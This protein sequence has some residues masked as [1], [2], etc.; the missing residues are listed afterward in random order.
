[1]RKNKFDDDDDARNLRSTPVWDETDDSPETGDRWSTWDQSTAGERGPQPY[2]DWLV[3]DLAAVDY[4]LGMVKTGKEADVELVRRAVPGTDRECLLAAKRYRSNQHR[5]FHRDAGYLEGRR[6]RESRTN[7]ATAKRTK[8]GREAIASQ[9]AAAEFGALCQLWE[10]GREFG[11]ELVP[12]PVQILGT[13]LLLEFIGTPEGVAAPRLAELRPEPDE[14]ADLWR[15][16]VDG[17]VVLARCGLAHGDLSA[18]NMLVHNGR[19]VLIDL[20]QVVD[21]IANPH[22]PGFLARDARNVANWFAAR[23][24]SD[25]DSERLTGELLAEA[26]VR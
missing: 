25:V 16:A 9:W 26:G 17:M 22:G 15:Q 24:L 18:Y 14:L 6:V 7:R 1:M 23:G 11:V 2:P 21:V 4:E 8:F 20:P 13:E 12:Y 19:L 10:V 3:T 5:M